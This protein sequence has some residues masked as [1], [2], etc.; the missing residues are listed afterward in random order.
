MECK[1]SSPDNHHKN[2]GDNHELVSKVHF[3]IH[4]VYLNNNADNRVDMSK[5]FLRKIINHFK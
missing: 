5:Y 4:S 2:G 3:P 1:N